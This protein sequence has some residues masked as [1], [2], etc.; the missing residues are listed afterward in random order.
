MIVY[1]KYSLT[2]SNYMSVINT[3]KAL[4]TELIEH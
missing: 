4:T 1:S 2:N 3:N